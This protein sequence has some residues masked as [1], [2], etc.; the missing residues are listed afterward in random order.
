M[1]VVNS[2][3]SNLMQVDLDNLDYFQNYHYRD[4]SIEASASLFPSSA[5]KARRPHR[6][7]S[8][9]QKKNNYLRDSLRRQVQR[10][11]QL[12]DA[13]HKSTDGFSADGGP[14][15]KVVRKQIAM[16]NREKTLGERAKFYRNKEGRWAF[17]VKVGQEQA[18]EQALQDRGLSP[19]EIKN[20]AN[21]TEASLQLAHSKRIQNDESKKHGSLPLTQAAMMSQRINNQQSRDTKLRPLPE[22]NAQPYYATLNS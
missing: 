17:N 2:A 21:L 9:E 15:L 1:Q 18:V 7:E 11:M 13:I 8:P 22:K 20:L 6:Q 19:E 12:I 5:Y 14:V 3:S 16:T 4:P 10:N